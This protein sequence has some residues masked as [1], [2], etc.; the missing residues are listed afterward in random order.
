M[1]CNRDGRAAAAGAAGGLGVPDAE[2]LQMAGRC[3]TPCP[4]CGAWLK[5]GVCQRCGHPHVRLEMAMGGYGRQTRSDEAAMTPQAFVGRFGFDPLN[6]P[7]LADLYS[8]YASNISGQPRQVVFEADFPTAYTNLQ[9]RIGMNPCPLD[10][11]TVAENVAV[12][13]G[14]LEHELLHE[15]FSPLSVLEEVL[16]RARA[17]PPQE[18]KYLKD[19]HN[20]LEDARIERISQ[21]RQPLVW[22]RIKAVHRLMPKHGGWAAPDKIGGMSPQDQIVVALVCD[23]QPGYRLTAELWQAFD[24]QVQ[25]ALRAVLPLA[26][27][28]VTGD[29]Q[30]CLKRT[31]RIFE[32]LKRRGLLTARMPLD[33]QSQPHGGQEADGSAQ[34]GVPSQVGE[35]GD[36]RA[37]DESDDSVRDGRQ[38]KPGGEEEEG[39]DKG[40][41]TRKAED[42]ER[43]GQPGGRR[44]DDGAGDDHRGRRT[45]SDEED[46]GP[47]RGSREKSAEDAGSGHRGE[48]DDE[49]A[50]S[51]RSRHNDAPDDPNAGRSRKSGPDEETRDDGEGGRAS[52]END[53][54][55]RGNGGHDAGDGG[56][57]ARATDAPNSG[58]PGFLDDD[59]G[60]A[61]GA[62]SPDVMQDAVNKVRQV[63]RQMTGRRQREAGN[64]LQNPLKPGQTVRVPGRRRRFD[65]E[66]EIPAHEPVDV[67]R[68]AGQGQVMPQAAQKEAFRVGS[69]LAFRLKGVITQAQKDRRLQKRGKL[70]RR[71]LVAAKKGSQRTRIQKSLKSGRSI[72][73][74]LLLDVSGSMRNE[75]TNLYQYS[76]A[77]ADG[78][79]KAGLPYEIINFARGVGQVKAFEERVTG[80][81][82]A[83]QMRGLYHGSL[84]STPTAEAMMASRASLSVREERQKVQFVF[85]DGVPDNMADAR[86]QIKENEAAGIITIGLVFASSGWEA[87][88]RQ[89]EA[90]FGGNAIRITDLAQFPRAVEGALA[91]LIAEQEKRGRQ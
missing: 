66:N 83:D 42:E 77:T 47:G 2:T 37:G 51:G 8:S 91:R 43:N 34:A 44:E 32:A 36:G 10:Q 30:G 45:G 41:R 21:K 50:D 81:K 25:D 55:G 68:R 38:W 74:S 33:W 82:L 13:L 80:Q 40:R 23:A 12:G 14:F 4:V 63:A 18:G 3:A 86:D 5:D 75:L 29:A 20:F 56:G 62:L 60:D 69:A 31:A 7:V 67:A 78:F 1:S 35:D 72:A 59:S 73:A 24:P 64:R 49:D 15:Q 84:G 61:A 26:Q 53:R 19:L 39:S 57:D 22:E 89:A 90:L 9:G 48:S 88:I 11:N 46:S 87:D 79:G 58:V 85:T 17:L 27:R 54:G 52:A 6:N 71:R 28:A 70:D 76:L 16:E 65:D